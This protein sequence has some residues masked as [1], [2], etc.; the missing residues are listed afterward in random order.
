MKDVVLIDLQENNFHF[1][2][3]YIRAVN[4]VVNVSF[5]QQ[6]IQKGYIIPIVT[7]WPGQIYLRIAISYYILYHEQSNIT[8]SIL[9]FLLIIGLLHILLNSRELVFLQYRPFFATM[10]KYI[11]EE[12]RPHLCKNPNYGVLILF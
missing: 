9:S 3:A 7:D 12:Q 2:N 10:Y 11:F 8:N 6:Y 4:A 5:M 1:I